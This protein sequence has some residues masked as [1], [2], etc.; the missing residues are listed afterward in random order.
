[1]GVGQGPLRP[2]P[3]GVPVCRAVGWGGHSPG[4]HGWKCPHGAHEVHVSPPGVE[5]GHRPPLPAPQQWDGSPQTSPKGGGVEG[6]KGREDPT[7]GH[8]GAGGPH[9][10]P[11]GRWQRGET[12]STPQIRGPIE[13][14]GGR[15]DPVLCGARLSSRGGHRG[16]RVGLRGGRG[17]GGRVMQL[18]L[19]PRE[20]SG[21]GAVRAKR[22]APPRPPQCALP[23]G[24]PRPAL[25]P[26]RAPIGRPR[27]GAKALRPRPS[28]AAPHSSAVGAPQEGLLWPRAPRRGGGEERG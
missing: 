15:G 21:P 20:Q 17:G 28:A 10:V 7:K 27:R 11:M 14:R 12:P 4:V 13:E 24:R 26:P 2:P 16:G 19:Q 9:T 5:W 23:D 6:P 3:K 18:T 8:S 25:R 22:G 1:M